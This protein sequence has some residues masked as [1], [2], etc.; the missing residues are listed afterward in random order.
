MSDATWGSVAEFVFGPHTFEVAAVFFA[1]AGIALALSADPAD[2]LKAH[3]LFA[4]AFL[5]TAGRIAHL[6]VTH[7]DWAFRPAL[8]FV[9]F[10]ALGAGWC[11]VYMW[12]EAKAP[13]V[14]PRQDVK[15]T[16]EEF[17]TELAKRFPAPPRRGRQLSE[18]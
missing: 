12:V 13:T 9:L 10:G 1:G 16:V 2:V 3:L 7:R 6:L 11:A 5:L 4:F 14:N 17:A 15:F 18:W 8:G